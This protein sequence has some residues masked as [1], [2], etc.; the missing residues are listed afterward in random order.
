MDWHI[1]GFFA[2]SK[3]GLTKCLRDLAVRLYRAVKPNLIAF[4]IA[5]KACSF[6]CT[7]Y[8]F[9]CNGFIT[10]QWDL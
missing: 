3:V 4:T 8:Y 5:Y 2:H 1:F 9:A 7:P 6:E 10:C